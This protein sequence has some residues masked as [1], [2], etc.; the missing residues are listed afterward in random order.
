MF[1]RKGVTPRDASA[2]R[3]GFGKSRVTGHLHRGKHVPGHAPVGIYNAS[4]AHN[5]RRR[6]LGIKV[7][8]R[9]LGEAGPEP[10]HVT[11]SNDKDLRESAH[12]RAAKPDASRAHSGADAPDLAAIVE[13]WP[14]LPAYVKGRVVALVR[15]ALGEQA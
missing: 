11:G 15:T 7:G 2:R 13:A 3:S 14:T 5:R 6:H 10:H 1:G 9:R 12:P 8:D 4:S